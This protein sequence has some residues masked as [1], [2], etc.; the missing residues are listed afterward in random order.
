MPPCCCACM[1]FSLCTCAPGVSTGVQMSFSYKDAGQIGSGSI[2]TASFYLV[3]SLKFL[4]PSAVALWGTGGYSFNIW[5]LEGYDSAHDTRS[6][7]YYN[8][9]MEQPTWA[10][11][12]C[13]TLNSISLMGWACSC[14]GAQLQAG[15]EIPTR[16]SHISRLWL[17]VISPML[18][19][20][21][22]LGSSPL[23]LLF[24]QAGQAMSF[25]GPTVNLSTGFPLRT[26]GTP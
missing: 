21:E 3:I 1:A 17:T 7:N 8:M 18:G 24:Q 22:W 16:V 26:L 9:H 6:L 19:W 15:Q 12:R 2:L 4:S 13:L 23:C 10:R 11:H 25:T 20:L 14:V 5:I